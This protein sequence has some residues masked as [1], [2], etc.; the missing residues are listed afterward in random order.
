MAN[1][2]FRVFQ[3]FSQNVP[4]AA[5]T[6]ASAQSNPFNAQTRVIR[7]CVTGLMT[8]TT[9]TGVRIEIGDNPTAT[10]TSL[11]LV[12][13]IPEYFIVSPGQKI[14]VLGN[15]TAT[16]NVGVTEMTN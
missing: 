2:P 6:G 1:Y 5:S 15:D 7:V 14:A 4:Y 8:A 13:N 9:G 10:A 3:G 16:G 12:P 11:L